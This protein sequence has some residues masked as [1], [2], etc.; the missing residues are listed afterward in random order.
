MRRISYSRR[1]VDHYVNLARVAKDL[2]QRRQPLAHSHGPYLLHA[3][4]FVFL[5]RG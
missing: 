3:R 4:R 5:E 1:V 2:P